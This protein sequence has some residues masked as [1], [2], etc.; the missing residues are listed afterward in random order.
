MKQGKK[1]ERLQ[2]RIANWERMNNPHKN[3]GGMK[4]PGSTKRN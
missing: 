1:R 4:C 3:A 2:R